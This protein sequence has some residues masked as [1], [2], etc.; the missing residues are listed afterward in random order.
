M[1]NVFILLHELFVLNFKL[2]QFLGLGFDNILLI[3]FGDAL[4]LQDFVL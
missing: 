2:L 1:L 4:L 3:L